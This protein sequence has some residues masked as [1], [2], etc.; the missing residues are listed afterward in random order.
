MRI[1]Q[2]GK[3]PAPRPAPPRT[4]SW[5]YGNG[6]VEGCPNCGLKTPPRI[7]P[8]SCPDCN[9]TGLILLGMRGEEEIWDK[10]PCGAG[11]D[12]R[13]LIPIIKA[14]IEQTKANKPPSPEL[15]DHGI[16]GFPVHDLQSKPNTSLVQ[17]QPQ[18]VVIGF[19]DQTRAE[20]D[21]A[22]E[23]AK[24][25]P[26]VGSFEDNQVA[27]G[28]QQS[29]ADQLRAVERAREDWVRPALDH[30][31]KANDA[32]KEFTKEMRQE[33]NRLGEL[34]GAWAS[35]EQ[36]KAKSAKIAADKAQSELTRERHERIANASTSEEIDLIDLE[37]QNRVQ[38][39]S[40]ANLA[41][42]VTTSGQ[43]ITEDW[44]IQ[45]TDMAALYAAH[46]TACSAP[47]PLLGAVKILLTAGVKVPGVIGTKVVVSKVR[48]ARQ[49]KAIEV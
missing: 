17:F 26:T 35:L 45:V 12:L 20:R 11:S 48:A 38:E 10:C 13:R 30:Q 2:L 41:P 25:M 34:C 19:S 31:K 7:I 3:N 32:A 8:N 5:C 43:K 18:T 21:Q 24:A 40:Q 33:M 16:T 9:G 1:N 46:P 39:L 42:K 36:E 47:K 4:C 44:D 28:I 14:N 23:L 27:T 22:L 29:L 6:T 15:E 37:H 49:P